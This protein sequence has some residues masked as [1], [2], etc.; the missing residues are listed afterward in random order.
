VYSVQ[1]VEMI[2]EG[3]EVRVRSMWKGQE[4]PWCVVVKVDK[5]RFFVSSNQFEA[6][7][8]EDMILEWQVPDD[9]EGPVIV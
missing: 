2:R 1:E 5:G 4:D 8:G 6:W 9:W 7:I 3:M